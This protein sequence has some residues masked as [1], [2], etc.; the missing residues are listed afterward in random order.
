MRAGEAFEKTSLL[1]KMVAVF[2]TF[3]YKHKKSSSQTSEKA[4]FHP[5]LRLQAN[6]T[7]PATQ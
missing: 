4:V 3:V 7:T 1:N 2:A 6:F 5:N